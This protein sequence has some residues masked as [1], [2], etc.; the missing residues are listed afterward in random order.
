[1][2]EIK[3]IQKNETYLELL[4]DQTFQQVDSWVQQ[5]QFHED[6]LLQFTNNF[7]ENVKRNQKNSKELRENFLE[8]VREWE[9]A[10]REELLTTTTAL[11]NLFPTKSYEEI[12]QQLDDIQNK[13][14]EITFTPFNNLD[15]SDQVDKLVRAL[16]QYVEFRRNNRI[17][18]VKNVKETASIIRENQSVLL[19]LMTKQVKNIFFPFHQIYNVQSNY[20]KSKFNQQGD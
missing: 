11:K 16:E 20:L 17:L 9:K 12:N 7:A 4:W 19:E 15:N 18:F 6:I 1:M 2:A 13:T 5:A 8:K 14:A 3:Q 10:S